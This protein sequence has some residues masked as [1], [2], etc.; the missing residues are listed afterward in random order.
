MTDSNEFEKVIFLDIEG[1]VVT[2]KSI[3]FNHTPDNP[4]RGARVPMWHH[5][6]DKLCMGLVY[7][8]AKDYAAK[9]VLTSTLRSD[10]YVHT[11]LL[12]VAPPWL[13]SLLAVDPEVCALDLL[14]TAVTEHRSSREEEI[15]KFV[16]DFAVKQYVVFD[17]RAL[18]CPNF[19]QV[20]QYDGIRMRD[21][22][23]AK[24]LLVSEGQE[25]E[26]EGIFL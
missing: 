1:V 21:F 12:A 3:L 5:Y 24:Y 20:D 7:L 11:G 10:K 19:I 13:N 6:I 2:H 23:K 17:D 26:H 14:S 9:I 15:A 18:K 25:I 22:K 16:E 8:L 4:Y